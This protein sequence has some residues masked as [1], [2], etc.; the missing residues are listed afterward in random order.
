MKKGLLTLFVIASNLLVSV[1]MMAQTAGTL[2]FSFTQI[3]QTPTYD[4]TKNALAVWIE[5]NSGTF[6]KTKLRYAGKG[7]G[8]SDHLPT[9]SVN[10][11]GSSTNCLA[12]TVNVTDATT[13]ATLTNFGARSITWD[14]KNVSGTTNGAVVADGSYRVAVEETWN[15]GTTGT[16]VTYFTFTK[17]PTVVTMSPASTAQFSNIHL[18]WTPTGV[19]AVDE[20][21]LFDD[22]SLYPNPNQGSFRLSTGGLQG[23]IEVDVMN[24]L[25]ESIYKKDFTVSAGENIPIEIPSAKSGLYF[26]RIQSGSNVGIKNF[27]VN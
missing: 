16:V 7:N 19:T 9:Y 26:V 21:S 27:N 18:A 11:G 23:K 17:G 15:H 22:V 25:G 4:G 8:T 6:V 24:T 12:T 3:A 2:T 5:T 10:A 1:Q 14:G 20:S 13:G